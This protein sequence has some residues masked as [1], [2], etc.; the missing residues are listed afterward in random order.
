MIFLND[1]T[2]TLLYIW[3]YIF[4]YNLTLILL[5]AT[6]FQFISTQF[7]SMSTLS[8]LG[9]NNYFSKVLTLSLFSM[10]GI[11]PFVGFFSKLFILN[12]IVNMNFFVMYFFFF[13]ILFFGLYFYIQNIRFLNSSSPAYYN[14][15]QDLQLRSPLLYTHMSIILSFTLIF[16]AFYLDDLLVV[17]KWLLI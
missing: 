4:I 3:T 14:T 15:I 8:M 16:G 9:N 6:L 2:T 7:F 5:F 11:P 10:A 12:L 1:Y 13:V 17:I